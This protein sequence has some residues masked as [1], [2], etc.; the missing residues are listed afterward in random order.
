MR[1]IGFIPRAR[2]I[3]PVG[4]VLLSGWLLMFPQLDIPPNSKS[5]D[6]WKILS[7]APITD[8]EQVGAYDSAQAC[9]DA[10]EA[11]IQK[12]QKDRNEEPLEIRGISP[13]WLF[14]VQAIKSRCVPADHIYPPKK[15]GN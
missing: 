15:P 9:E 13:R 8:W 10:R 4:T 12:T 11:G 3:P 6:E 14:S 1:R 5:V 7:G 2:V